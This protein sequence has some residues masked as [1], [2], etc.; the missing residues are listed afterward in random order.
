M[1]QAFIMILTLPFQCPY[2]Y[3]MHKASLHQIE[4]IQYTVG[5]F[6]S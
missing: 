2:Y 3:D 4:N 6:V 1:L 5:M